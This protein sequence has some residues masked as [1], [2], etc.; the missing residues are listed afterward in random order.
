LEDGD[1]KEK[2]AGDRPVGKKALVSLGPAILTV[3]S[4]TYFLYVM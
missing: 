2:R 1:G 3:C 4:M